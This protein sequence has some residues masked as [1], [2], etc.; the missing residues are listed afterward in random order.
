MGQDHWNLSHQGLSHWNLSHY[1]LGALEFKPLKA[2]HRRCNVNKRQSCFGRKKNDL[3]IGKKP[4][5]L[6]GIEEEN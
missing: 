4:L 5:N 2:S 6:I 3:L 1:G